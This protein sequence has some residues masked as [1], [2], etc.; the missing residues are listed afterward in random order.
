MP[1]GVNTQDE[2][3]IQGR[4]VVN[5]N[6]SNIVAPGIV[7]DGLVLH[8]DAGNY[9]SYPIAGTTWY[10]L[11]GRGNNGTLTNGPTYDRDGGG[12]INLDGTNDY[13]NFGQVLPINGPWAL[14]AWCKFSK[15]NA[16][17]VILSR[18]AGSPNYEQ[19]YIIYLRSNNKFGAT[20]S[21]NSYRYVEGTTIANLGV[22]Y[23][24]VGV[25]DAAKVLS[26]YVNGVFEGSATAL[27]ED[28]PTTGGQYVL[29]S[30]ANGAEPTYFIG[31]KV[32]LASIYNRA[33]TPSEV[34]QNFN[35][36]R[37]RFNI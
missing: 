7:T 12:T 27:T 36:L 30:A 15:L 37:S 26:I 33:L 11:S 29:L 31:A 21:A 3:R 18:S 16:I 2:G 14:T 22:W 5:A 20:T 10:D 23:F 32:P 35:A 25:Y 9:E 8:L 17:Q 13:V 19:N 1:R 34:S 4:N 6:S 24:V 28:P